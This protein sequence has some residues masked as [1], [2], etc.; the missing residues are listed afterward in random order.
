MDHWQDV[1]SRLA[2]WR[3]AERRA[4]HARPLTA[5]RIEA[6]REVALWRAAYQAAVAGSEPQGR[7][8]DAGT[9]GTEGNARQ[10]D[11]P[12]RRQAILG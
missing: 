11:E 7:D 4:T 12:M 5:E 1:Q 8:A 6:D 9:A 10:D 2:E 3:A